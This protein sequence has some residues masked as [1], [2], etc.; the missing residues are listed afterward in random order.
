MSTFDMQKKP[1][2]PSIPLLPAPTAC[3][4]RPTCFCT[5]VFCVGQGAKGRTLTAS[6]HSPG[7]KEGIDYHLVSWAGPCP[8]PQTGHGHLT[9]CIPPSCSSQEDGTFVQDGI[10]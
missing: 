3:T 10:S 8:G 9:E 2:R 5:H 4:A 1:L 6:V 7:R